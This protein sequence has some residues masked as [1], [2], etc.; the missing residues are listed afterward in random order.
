MHYLFF[1]SNLEETIPS[2]IQ[3]NMLYKVLLLLCS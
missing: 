2:Q 1:K 3:Y